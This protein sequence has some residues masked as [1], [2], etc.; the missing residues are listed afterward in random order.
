VHAHPELQPGEAAAGGSSSDSSGSSQA[1]QAELT[2][3]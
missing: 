3:A 2:S 1:Q